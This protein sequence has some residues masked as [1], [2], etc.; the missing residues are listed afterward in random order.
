MFGLFKSASINDD[1]LGPFA[2]RGGDWVGTIDLADFSAIEL[3]LDGDR[4][5][6]FPETL[7]AAYALPERLSS[8]VPIIAAALLDHLEPYQDAMQDPAEQQFFIKYIPDPEERKQIAEIATAQQAWAAS[9]IIGVEIGRAKGKVRLLIKIGTS[10]DVEHTLGAYF[11]DW[12][13]MELNGS[14]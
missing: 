2:R 5:A 3:R 4:K 12:E 9:S 11:D 10:W 8:L 14:V 6:P 7:R 13:F 1:V